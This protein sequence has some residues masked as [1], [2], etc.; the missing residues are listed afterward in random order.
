MQ[1]LQASL[2]ILYV[3]YC[4]PYERSYGSQLRSLSILRALQQCGHTRVV[5]TA[6]PGEHS[7][8]SASRCGEFD[9]ARVMR[10]TPTPTP[11][12]DGRLR[13]MYDPLYTRVQGHFAAVE[14]EQWLLENARHTD[15]VW[16]YDLRTANFFATPRWDKSVLD[17]NDLPST[18]HRSVLLNGN[19]L[20]ERVKAAVQLLKSRRHERQLNHRFTVLSVCSEQDRS[21]MSTG[22]AVH[23][24][25]N[26]YPKPEGPPPRNPVKPV[27]I[28]FVGPYGYPPNR[29]G[30]HWFV[31]QCWPIVR[32]ELPDARLRLVGQG[33]DVAVG[34]SAPGVEA[35]GWAEELAEE[36]ASWSLMIVPIRTGSGTR[37]KIPDAFSRKCPVVS[38]SI[39]ARGYDVQH[40]RELLLANRPREFAEACINLIQGPAQ[41]DAMA[42]RAY[43][44]F[45]SQWTWDS[46]AKPVR[47]ALEDCA[48][49]ERGQGG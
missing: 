20:I 33:T 2:N 40:R 37:V 21:V 4:W 16:F 24:I 30:L 46:V 41:A 49:V 34:L 12:L 25:P 44:R 17:V 7:E 29:E 47:A 36:V 5:V 38:T 23:V 45:L 35:L 10:L 8:T 14:D 22:G 28:G 3:T 32:R 48:R 19:G 11:P 6:F 18:M 15:V 1:L 39:G 26:G 9:I 27:R 42:D 31:D 43:H 13:A